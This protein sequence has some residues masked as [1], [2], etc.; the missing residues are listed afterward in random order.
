VAALIA[1]CVLLIPYTDTILEYSTEGWLWALFGLSHRLALERSDAQALWTRYGV[2]SAAGLAYIIRETQDYGFDTLQSVVLALLI[3]GLILLLL[4]F[5]RGDLA[6]QPPE[7]VAAF[8][9]F[10][11]R[12]SLE[13]YALSLFAMQLLAYGLDIGETE[14]E[15]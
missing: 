1:L 6:W 11:G 3:A 13:I 12:R 2:A 9:R 4:R 10:V 15:E 5:H 7:L 8:F 14:D